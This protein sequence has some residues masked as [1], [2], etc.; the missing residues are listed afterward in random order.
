MSYPNFSN[1]EINYLYKKTKQRIK[2]KKLRTS[3]NQLINK[4]S[5]V[6]FLDLEEPLKAPLGELLTEPY[7]GIK[8]DNTILFNEKKLKKRI[9]KIK[10]PVAKG[11]KRVIC[12]ELRTEI[13]G[14]FDDDGT[15][16]KI[17]K[18]LLEAA[19]KALYIYW[20]P[21]LVLEEIGISNRMSEFIV[22]QIA[23]QLDKCIENGLARYCAE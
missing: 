16:Q 11:I 18:K 13:K 10:I 12:E 4:I 23:T 6:R 22:D 2:N 21:A 19:F 20:P 5:Q 14:F 1:E 7:L 8:L 9:I 3:E 17:M 15:G